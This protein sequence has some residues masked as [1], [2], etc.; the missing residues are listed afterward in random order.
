MRCLL[1]R[2]R[3]LA[4]LTVEISRRRRQNPNGFIMVLYWGLW[5]YF[6]VVFTIRTIFYFEISTCKQQAP[7]SIFI[8]F[9]LLKYYLFI[10][11]CRS[12][13]NAAFKTNDFFE[14]AIMTGITR[15]SRESIFSD[16][17]IIFIIQFFYIMA[18]HF[19]CF[20]KSCF[21]HIR[22]TKRNHRKCALQFPIL[23]LFP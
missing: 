22:K 19:S 15:V 9:Q 6:I 18:Y 14:R 1:L 5:F 10:Y 16:L 8:L 12:L 2:F 13:F 7:Y 21:L 20:R 17:K 4:A 3:P 11:H 23:F